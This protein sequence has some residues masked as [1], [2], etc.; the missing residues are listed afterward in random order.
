M[1]SE[2]SRHAA[3]DSMVR[4]VQT[5]S[6]LNSRPVLDRPSEILRLGAPPDHGVE[7]PGSIRLYLLCNDGPVPSASGHPG[8]HRPPATYGA[9]QQ[10]RL[11]SC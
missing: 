1:R 8:N 9:P 7:Y 3:H 11:P 5:L 6:I 4:K 10:K 2:A